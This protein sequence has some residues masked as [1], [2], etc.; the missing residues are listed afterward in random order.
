MSFGSKSL[1]QNIELRC[2]YNNSYN[3]SSYRHIP[4]AQIDS[5][6]L[7][8]ILL[9]ETLIS[10]YNGQEYVFSIVRSGNS[11]KATK[12]SVSDIMKRKV[13]LSILDGGGSSL[14]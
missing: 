4:S 10:T 2:Q 7:T 1:I 12:L 13:R 5:P 9:K 3:S 6:T 8:L 14:F 11:K